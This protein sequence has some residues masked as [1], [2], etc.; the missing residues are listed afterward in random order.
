MIDRD[1]GRKETYIHIPLPHGDWKDIRDRGTLVHGDEH[2]PFATKVSD[3]KVEE[4]VND[5]CFINLPQCS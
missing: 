5:K 3:E 4:A 2:F 1:P